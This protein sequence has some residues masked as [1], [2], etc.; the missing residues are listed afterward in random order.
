[1]K[2]YRHDTMP[3]TSHTC[4]KWAGLAQSSKG[5]YCLCSSSAVIATESYVS[6]SHRN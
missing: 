6:L 2:G 5:G 4:F 1:M 3:H